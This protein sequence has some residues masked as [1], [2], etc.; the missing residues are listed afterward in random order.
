MTKAPRSRVGNETVPEGR[1]RVRRRA[2]GPASLGEAGPKT[3]SGGSISSQSVSRLRHTV[4]HTTTN[5]AQQL[6]D[7][8]VIM[9]RL[10]LRSPS[11]AS[12]LRGIVGRRGSPVL[13]IA[14]LLVT[15]AVGVSSL[16]DSPTAAQAATT[17][18][19]YYVAMGDSLAAGTGASTTADDYVSLVYQHE[20]ARHPGLQLENLGCGA[21]RPPQCSMVRAARTRRAPNWAMPRPSCAPIPARWGC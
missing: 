1:R 10:H 11:A 6:E 3:T 13:A 19:Q 15:L 18:V 2:A 9:R 4:F 5:Y 14:G 20:L 16:A 12:S 17:A 7:R 21:R 8:G